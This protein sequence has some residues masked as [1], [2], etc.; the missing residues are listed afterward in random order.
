MDWFASTARGGIL[1]ILSLPVPAGLL[2]WPMAVAICVAHH[3]GL[4]GPHGFARGLESC[5]LPSMPFGSKDLSPLPSSPTTWSSKK[6][7][8][9]SEGWGA[10]TDNQLGELW[11]EFWRLVGE[12]GKDSIAI[13]WVPSH[14]SNKPRILDGVPFSMWN[15]NR[16]ADGYA[17]QGAMM[18]PKKLLSETLRKARELSARFTLRMVLRILR[19]YAR[20]NFPDADPIPVE[21]PRRGKQRLDTKGHCLIKRGLT[22]HCDLCGRIRHT[23]R[24]L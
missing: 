12:I 20:S 5:G 9:R 13:E 19:R 22:W 3:M 11:R 23:R 17:E 4:S 24:G 6:A 15:G 8:D 16:L 18:H 10:T 21:A 2:S 14:K 7:W 1:C